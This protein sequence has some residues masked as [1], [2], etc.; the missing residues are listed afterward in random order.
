MT[1]EKNLEGLKGWLILIGIGLVLTPLR[2]MYESL[3]TFSAIFTDGSWGVLTSPSSEA[4]NPLW[5]P[6]LLAEAGILFSLVVGWIFVAYLFFLK[7]KSF[8]NW[9]ICLLLF[10]FAFIFID[11]AGIYAIRPDL[12]IFDTDT[13]IDIARS[14]IVCLIWIPYMR[15]SK[16]VKAT[17]IR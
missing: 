9:Y 15:I 8:P 14:L 17:F 6:I 1:E 11:A 3:P 12:P 4:Y 7:K 16:R 2:I 5:G 10:S 13:K